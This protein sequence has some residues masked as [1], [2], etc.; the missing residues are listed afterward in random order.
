MSARRSDYRRAT[1]VIED[2]EQREEDRRLQQDRQATGERVGAVLLL[3]L[4]ISWVS[5]SCVALVLLL[6][7]LHLRLQACMRP[8]RLD[9][10][11]KQR[12]QQNA[13]EQRRARRSTAPRPHRCRDRGPGSTRSGGQP[14]PTRRRHRGD[15]EV[16]TV[17]FAP[18]LVGTALRSADVGTAQVRAGRGRRLQGSTG[19][20]AARRRRVSQLPRTSPWVV[21]ASTAY[22]ATAGGEAAP[23]HVVGPVEEQRRRS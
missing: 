17:R 20:S 13:D 4:L 12:N 2:V 9:L 19:G 11:D 1:H 14:R 5:R 7:L 15:R 3:Q 21:S 10:L 23:R 16:R 22:A 18:Q 8:L 6:Q